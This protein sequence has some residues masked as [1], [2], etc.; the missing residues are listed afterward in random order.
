MHQRDCEQEGFQWLVADDKDQSVY[1]F[2]RSAPGEKPA[3]VISN[4]TPEPR[5]NYRVP[6]PVSGRWQ[7][8][9]NSDAAIYAGS[10][11]GN[12]GSVVAKAGNY[13]G[14][15]ASAEIT[16]PPLSTLIFEFDI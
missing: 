5:K 15:A 7:E 6:L 3:A 16:L 10:G 8:R 14:F 11:M 13:R 12:G 9:M 4:L 1:A 2:L